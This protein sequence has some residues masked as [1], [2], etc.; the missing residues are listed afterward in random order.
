[1]PDSVIGSCQVDKDGTGLLFR[2][3]CILNALREQSDLIHGG[4]SASKTRLFPWEQRVNKNV[5]QEVSDL[6]RAEPLHPANVSG[7]FSHREF[8]AALQHLK[9]GKAPGP[10]SIC[11]ELIIHAGAG[12]KS[13]LRGFLSSCL[14]HLKIPKIWRRALVVAVPNPSKP[15]E[16]PRSYRP[17]SL[18]CVP[19]KILERLIYVRVESLIVTFISFLH[20]RIRASKVVSNKLGWTGR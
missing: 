12:L 6:W 3:E 15:V 10:D 14:H 5:L 16:H 20:N 7:S 1:M 19:F 17:I 11:P 9:P 13:W 4:S 8:A 18:L 2:F